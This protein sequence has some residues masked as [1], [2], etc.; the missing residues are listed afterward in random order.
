[1]YQIADMAVWHGRSD[2]AEGDLGLR[3]HQVVS[4]V[5]SRSVAGGVAIVGFSCDAGVLRNQGRGGAK[6]G[7][8][9]VRKMLA[10]F[11]VRGQPNIVD[12]G[13]VVCTAVAD[14][15]GLEKAQDA[16]ASLLS[17]LLGRELSP[18]VIGG[19]HEIAYGSFTGLT[20]H[21]ERFDAC[22]L[23]G[24]I[25]LDAHLDLR[26]GEKGSSGTPFRQIA[27]DC[28]TKGWPF[29]YLCLGVSEFANTRSL[30]ERGRA[31]NAQWMTDDEIACVSIERIR[32]RIDE[33]I[34]GVDHVYLSICLDVLPAS[35]APGVSA[36]AAA[37]VALQ[38]IEAIVSWVAKC[39]KLRL[40]DIAELNPKLDID[41]RTARVAAR[42]AARLA[43]EW[44]NGADRG[45]DE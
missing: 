12:A 44:I 25:N 1:M 14:D 35:V 31:L 34:L 11:P 5:V 6:Y 27:E 23:V 29:H 36:P 43:E 32:N 38:T 3:W 7:P 10:N 15:D 17:Y 18:I 37:G 24:V 26:K 22:P 28:A 45:K 13:N 16:L 2:Y 33:F 19:G 39:G 30:F 9:V 40:A 42:L 21:L 20:R 8:F 4:G 41:D